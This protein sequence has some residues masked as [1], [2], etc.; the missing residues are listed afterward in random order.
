M[1][2]YYAQVHG[3]YQDGTTWSFGNH[4]TSSQPIG[5]LLTTWS[6]AWTAAWTDGTHGLQTIYPTTTVM[7]SFTV[8][9]LNGSMREVEKVNAASGLAGGSS[10]SSL[11]YM[12]AFLVSLR[13]NLIQK[14]NRGRIYLPAPVEGIVVNDVYTSAAATRVRDAIAAAYSAIRADGST[15]FVTNMKK[16]KDDTPAFQKTVITTQ[17]ASRKPARQSRRV[18]K[19]ATIYV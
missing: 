12:L 10:D 18:T 13:S 17:K 8:A 16:L 2:D 9:R 11:P 3:T 4:I 7:Q 6:N 14:T 19:V 15:I 1:T 5:T